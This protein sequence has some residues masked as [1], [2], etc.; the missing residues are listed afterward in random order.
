MLK[1]KWFR[2]IFRQRVL[3]ILLLAIQL[4]L[5]VF[6]I[7]SRG[8]ASTVLRIILNIISV[9][10]SCYVIV[11]QDSIPA[12]KLIWVFLILLFPFF[13]G[14]FYLLFNFQTS[15]KR[16]RK[17]VQQSEAKTK[18]LLSHFEGDYETAE[19]E[20]PEYLPQ[21]TYL[22]DLAGFPIYKNTET[23]YLTPG[24]AKF[25]RLLSELEKAEKY[26]FLEYFI[27]QEGV[28]WNAVLEVLKR[29]AAEGVKVRLMYDDFGCFVLLPKNYPEQLKKY[30]IECAIFNP[31]R[32]F[33]T[34]KQNNRDHRK[35]VSIDG[36][37]AFT[38]GINL[39][40][41]YINVR[42]RHGH[43]KDASIVLEGKAAWSMTLMFLQMWAIVTKADEDFGQ[44][45]P[46]A[47]E[48]C[49]VE[50]KG[51]VQPYADSP[52]DT[53]NVGE[54][55]YMQILHNAKKY[56]YINTPYLIVD[57]HMLSA[58]CLAAKSGI[59]VRI[60]TPQNGDKWFVHTTT[61]SYYRQLLRAGVKIYE[62]TGGFIHSKTFVSDDRV[63][64]VG[65]TNLDYRSLYLHFEC[66]V[67]MCD[68]KAVHEVRDDFLETLKKCTPITEE[69]CKCGVFKRT[70]QD[71]LRLFAPFM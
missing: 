47:D 1:Q 27:V 14:L 2:A 41:E 9:L 22:Q 57:D 58:L 52:M 31:F 36:K 3:I 61:R 29:K 71:F 68:T 26:I 4:A 65:T 62:Y 34:I 67:W 70:V 10:V 7:A 12:Y 38:G 63:A 28:M 21:V 54:H 32:P 11:R 55:V 56:V 13:G 25:E 44:Y 59:D 42:E 37:V 48:P 49:A 51:F 46:Y 40:D 23:T 18:K 50:S 30:G 19:K 35:I 43:W 53:E 45:Y 60:V 20:I 69:D 17:Q 24:E 6:I 33:L 15:T 5:V 8:A 66:G 16:F 39:A 64:T